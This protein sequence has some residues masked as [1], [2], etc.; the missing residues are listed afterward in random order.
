MTEHRKIPLPK[1]GDEEARESS[2]FERASGTFGYDPFSPA[3]IEG[4]LPD[5]RMKRSKRPERKVGRTPEQPAERDE[6]VAPVAAPAEQVRPDPVEAPAPVFEPAP[7]PVASQPEAAPVFA[8]VEFA[9]ERHV[10][11]R[12]L[13]KEQ[14]MIVPGGQP[15]ALVEEFRIVKRQVLTAARKRDDAQSRRVL[16]S[17]PHPQEGKTFCSINLALSIASE[18]E[19]EVLLVDADTANPSVVRRLGLTDAR[20]LTDCLTDDALRP[21]DCVLGTDIPGLWVMP[22]GSNADGA[23]DYLAGSR[24]ADVLDRLSQGNP[25]RIVIFDTPPALAASAAAELAKHAGQTILVA[26]A[27][28]TGQNALEDAVDLLSACPD[29][30]LL[31]NGAHFSPSG[32]KFG[33]YGGTGESST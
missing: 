11:D 31:L 17:S 2:L 5:V 28:S 13:L 25:D 18:R 7:Q 8:P 10:I 27:E 23:G 29:I 4:A 26:R 19:W 3:P 30:K 15:T 12:A 9:G 16:V 22:A 21:E 20:G 32:R 14:G 1:D 33:S 6:P 24:T